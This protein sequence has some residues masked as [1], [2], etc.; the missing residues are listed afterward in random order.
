VPWQAIQVARASDSSTGGASDG[1]FGV[2]AVHERLLR[3]A[4]EV[5]RRDVVSPVRPRPS[6]GFGVDRAH[7]VDRLVD[8]LLE[9]V[10][11]RLPVGGSA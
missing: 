5:P 9:P 10:G 6:R 4:L 1:E 11:Q 2:D 3:D 7:D 8:A